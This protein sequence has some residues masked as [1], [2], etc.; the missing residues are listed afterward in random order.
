MIQFQLARFHKS[1]SEGVSPRFLWGD[2][3][4]SI[5]NEVVA[6]PVS[7]GIALLDTKSGK[8]FTLNAVGE[9][10]W[11]GVQHG[12]DANTIVKAILEKYDAPEATIR[13]DVEALLADLVGRGLLA[14]D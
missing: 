13:R 5:P 1:N 7:S 6:A 11:A 8:Y 10:V 4:F 3:V 2:V 12:D 14:Q 9:M